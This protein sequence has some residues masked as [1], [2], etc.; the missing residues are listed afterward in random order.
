MLQSL[1]T[2]LFPAVLVSLCV[3]NLPLFLLDYMGLMAIISPTT[4]SKKPRISNN[5][6]TFDPSGKK[7]LLKQVLSVGEI[8]I[9]SPHEDSQLVLLHVYLTT[10]ELTTYEYIQSKQDDDLS[11]VLLFVVSFSFSFSFSL[12][13]FPFVQFSCSCSFILLIIRFSFQT[14]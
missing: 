7:F 3:V 2:E 4:I 6:L 14:F 11:V 10:Q 5:N 13:F 9:E 12:V 8:I 1:P